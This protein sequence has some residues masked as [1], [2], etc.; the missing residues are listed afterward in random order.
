MTII[1]ITIISFVVV[2]V[3]VLNI[4]KSVITSDQQGS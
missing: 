3:V 2:V 1:I 4:S